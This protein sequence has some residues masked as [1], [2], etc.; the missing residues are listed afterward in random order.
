MPFET[1]ATQKANQMRWL[2]PLCFIYMFFVTVAGVALLMVRGFDGM[3]PGWAFSIG[4]DVF[5]MAVCLMLGYSC[6][7]TRDNVSGY[8]RIFLTLLALGSMA[9]FLDECAWLVQ[10]IP[11]L[12]TWNLIVNVLYY[13]NS[14]VFIFYFWRYV[15]YALNLEGR[16]MRFVNDFVSVLLAPATV[17]CFVNF[18]Y[19][20]FFSVDAATGNYQRSESGWVYSQLFLAVGLVAVIL[21]LIVSK[22]K[23][24]V[25]LTTAS[26]VSIPLINQ[27]LTQNAFGISTQ[28]AAM[29]VSVVLIY[30]VLFSDREKA[31]A[32]TGQ[33]LALATRIQADMLPNIFPAFPERDEFDVYASMNPAKEVGGDF[34]DFFLVDDD[35]LALVMADVSGKGIPA[36]LFMMVSKILVQ[37]YTMTGRSPKQVLEMVNSQICQNNREEMF[38]TVWLG[39][40]D[41][42]TGVLTAA[43]A[44][45]EYPVLKQPDGDFELIKDK[46]GFVI[47]GM[48]GMHYSEYQ[49]TMAPGAKLFL[50]TDG[51]AEA[52]NAEQTL[53]GTDR[54]LE[55]LRQAQD[56][57][58][59]DVLESVNGAVATFVDTAPQFD[60]LTMLCVEYKGKKGENA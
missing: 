1:K 19:P 34:Y 45:H 25:K 5:G 11:S 37:N 29:L 46:H 51:V 13:A 23:V 60:D 10:G 44:G 32:A 2:L 33:E 59:K 42:N 41:L 4:A 22:A 24:G 17:A 54:M 21:A 12:S 14:N 50:Y 48:D 36:A 6:L 57:T 9:L 31:L 27:L 15:T 26:F 43:N 20:L 28:Y 35:H 56:Q 55:A 39:I 52:T 8:T 18:F 40:L 30:G 3:K 49:F 16:F 58:T 7:R 38:V 47:G 53:F